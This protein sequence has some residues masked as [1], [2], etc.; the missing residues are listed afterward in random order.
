MKV[1]IDLDMVAHE[2]G[3]LRKDDGELFDVRDV[4]PIAKGRILSIVMGAQSGGW[5]GWLTRGKHFRHVAATMLKYKGNRDGAPRDNVDALKDMFHEDLGAVWCDDREA[6][7]AMAT[8]QW[9]DLVDV[10][11]K[12]GWEDDILKRVCNTVIATRDKDLDTVP[13]WHFKWWLKGGKDRGGTLVTEERRTVEKGEA[14]W[15]TVIE[16]F[17]NFYKQLLMGDTSDNIKGLYGVGKKSVW[18]KQLDDMEDEYEMYMHVEEKYIKYY[19]NYGKRFLL[20]CARLLHMQRWR[21]DKWMPPHE[22]DPHYWF[23]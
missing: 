11:M 2:L 12:F 16:A 20:E 18:L 7:D 1:N 10:G 17:R 4:A 3:H 22:R 9:G 15:I 13:G 23:I 14:Y 8:E 19:G 6:D 21:K 5:E